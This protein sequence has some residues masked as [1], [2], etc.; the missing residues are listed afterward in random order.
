MEQSMPADMP[1]MID[2]NQKK[3]KNSKPT[4]IVDGIDDYNIV[5]ISCGK[6]HNI[7][8]TEKSK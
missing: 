2:S 6:K 8:I 5:G 3:K 1:K 4:K 7:L